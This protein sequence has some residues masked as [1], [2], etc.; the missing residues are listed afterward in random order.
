VAGWGAPNE[1]P[2][3]K[4]R[5]PA[6]DPSENSPESGGDR[7]ASFLELPD[8]VRF[9]E[10]WRGKRRGR[11]VPSR[12][13]IDPIDIPW[14]LPWTFLMDYE[15]PRVFRYRL[16]GQQLVDVFGRNL[17]GCTL[18]DVLSPEVL[19]S[20]TDRWM[21]LVERRAVVCMKGLIYQAKDRLPIGERIMLPLADEDGGPI[22]GLVGMTVYTWVWADRLPVQKPAEV[23]TIPAGTIP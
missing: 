2:I 11:D 5:M 17:K 19:P 3:R 1:L 16:A 21:P 23:L 20:V 13:D 10:Y 14:A 15:H 18:A 12:A 9:F 7:I 22:T 8:I 4:S 6:G